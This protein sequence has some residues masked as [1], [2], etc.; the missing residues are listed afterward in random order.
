MPNVRTV[1]E[2]VLQIIGGAQYIAEM[3]AAAAAT[4]TLAAADALLNATLEVTMGL[5]GV[6]DP[7]LAFLIGIFIALTAAVSAT[8]ASLAAFSAEA[9]RL[10]QTGVILKNT[11]SSLSL[12]DVQKFAEETSLA[13]GI[14]RPGIE[15]TAGVLARTGV[16]GEQI[17]GLLST[18]ADTARATGKSFE[19]VGDAIEKGILGRVRGLAQF[20]IVLQDTGSKAANLALIQQQLQ[21]RFEGAAAAFRNTLPGAID[22]FQSSLQR[23]FSAL[24]E[25]FAPLVIRVLNGLVIMID[26]FTAHI[27]QFATALAYILGGPLGVM[28]K[29]AALAADAGNNPMAAVGHGGDPATEATALQIADNTARLADAVEQQVLGGSGEVARQSFGYLHARIAMSI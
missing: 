27:E 25:Q 19:D 24:G 8:T 28:L 14:S 11:T 23:F 17:R 5:L 15:G 26:F 7:L 4:G 18:I 20:G 29:N 12:P 22:A 10:F 1:V 21:I 13:T 6:A 9:N 2:D 16:S 3:T